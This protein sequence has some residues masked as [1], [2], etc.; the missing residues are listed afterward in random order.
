MMHRFIKL[1]GE[2]NTQMPRHVI[3]IISTSLNLN[4]KSINGSNIL[5]VGVAYKPD[6][7]DTRESPALDI[8]QLLNIGGAKID[9]YDPHVA[10]IDFENSFI[11]KINNLNPSELKKYD[12]C[13]IITN[14]KNIDYEC[15]YQN[16]RLII[17]TRN[18][19]HNRNGKHIVRLG[20]G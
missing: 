11:K 7:E 10:K 4:H 8:I 20:Q 5:I 19:Y 15:I 16:S 9:Y 13:L 18:V 3:E 6:I 2:I 17:D 1:A 14:H 12:A